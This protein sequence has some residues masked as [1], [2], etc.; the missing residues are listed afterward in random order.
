[1][2]SHLPPNRASRSASTGHASGHSPVAAST[3]VRASNAVSH[4]DPS[5]A[6]EQ[7]KRLLRSQKTT[8]RADDMA[9]DAL[10]Q[11]SDGTADR[12]FFS[13]VL[14]RS[15]L[16]PERRFFQIAVPKLWAERRES[17]GKLPRAK[18]K[19]GTSISKETQRVEATAKHMI[20]T[21][22]SKHD[23]VQSANVEGAGHLHKS[24][25]WKDT[26]D[27]VEMGRDVAATALQPV[28]G[29]GEVAS[30][31]VKVV[32]GVVIAGSQQ[33]AKN[34]AR[35]AAKA[36]ANALQQLPS[37]DDR[38]EALGAT[39]NVANEQKHVSSVRR[40]RVVLGTVLNLGEQ[41]TQQTS[42][43]LLKPLSEQLLGSRS[44][45]IHSAF[46]EQIIDKTFQGIQE[47]VQASS[48]YF[49][50]AG[51]EQRK[52]EASSQYMRSLDKLSH[53]DAMRAVQGQMADWHNDRADHKKR[54]TSVHGEMIANHQARV[55]HKERLSN[56]HGEMLANHQARAV[57]KERMKGVRE[58]LSDR[59]LSELQKASGG[60]T[61]G[62]RFN[63][64]RLGGSAST[65]T[66]LVNSLERAKNAK[67]AEE[68]ANA[69]R[70]AHQHS[71]QWLSKGGRGSGKA[72]ASRKAAIEQIHSHLSSRVGAKP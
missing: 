25:D 17:D 57:H 11:G 55:D 27:T 32:G 42:Q 18:L 1:M 3:S 49:D 12:G 47:G 15:G 7:E 59:H 23:Y 19:F 21:R 52:R 48:G 8:A 30:Q 53:K 39:E 44:E 58:E 51:A 40:N 45:E 13:R 38:R 33:M 66:K 71:E 4:R 14:D 35:E 6:R 70:E 43:H 62:A 36:T 5:A 31:A 28:P 46:G 60:K 63:E 26:A 22:K 54:L 16:R 61:L 65:H 10:M 29:V 24:L 72:A 50:L 20:M 68:K 2:D 69:L 37:M 64:W 67:S 34:E 9:T 56:V 41:A